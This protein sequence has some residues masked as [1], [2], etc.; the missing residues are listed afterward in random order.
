MGRCPLAA[1][2]VVVAATCILA[3][4]A[5]ASRAA[6]RFEF[7]RGDELLTLAK[8]GEP[9][10]VIVVADDAPAPVR[11]AGLELKE[12]LDAMTGG[13]FDVVANAPA[14]GTCIVLGDTDGARAAGIDAEEIARDGYAIR[15]VGHKIYIAGRD[16]PTEKSEVLFRVKTPFGREAGRYAMVKELGAGRWD[17]E[18]GTLYGAYR[19]LEELGVR[20]FFAGEKG[21][22]VPRKKDLTVPAF[23]L[24]EEP[25]YILRAVGG[26][27]WQWYMLDSARINRMV[28]REEYEDLGWD[29]NALRLWLLRVRHS[30][31]WFAFNHRPTR[32]DL[33]PRYGKEHPEYFALRENGERDPLPH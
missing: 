27:T 33:E 32:M 23:S 9:H 13:S 7:S 2:R 10:A 12:H 28:K 22:V 30:S 1:A 18:R 17:F 5:P 14:S 19:F 29:G 4:G 15:T 20:W 11:F 3:A 16:D 24:H 21:R 6:G 31:E 26:S 25:A 8:N